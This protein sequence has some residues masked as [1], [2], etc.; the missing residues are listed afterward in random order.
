VRAKARNAGRGVALRAQIAAIAGVAAITVTA[1]CAVVKRPPTDVATLRAEGV[2][3]AAAYQEEMAAVVER[4]AQR[5]VRRGDG[6]L[7][8]LLLSGGGQSGAFGAGF[9][10]GWRA[11]AADPMPTFDL[12]TG[13]SAGALQAPFAFLGTEEA[14]ERNARLFRNENGK[15]EPKAD[16]L[17]WLRRTGGVVK[18]DGFNE[19]L[20][21]TYNASLASSLAPGFADGRQ[22]LVGTTDADLGIGRMWDV[23][24]ELD[25]SDGV[26][27]LQR[28]LLASTAVP[29][30]FPPVLLDGH[31]HFDGSVMGNFL[32]VLDLEQYRRLAARLR[33]LGAGAVTVRL[34][35]ILNV[36]PHADIK[37]MPPEEATSLALRATYLL[38]WA[39][40]PEILRGLAERAAAANAELDGL[41]VELRYTGVPDELSSDPKA[42]KLFDA[43]WTK[44][45][46]QLGYER[47]LGD[48]PWDPIPSAFAR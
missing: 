15:M 39:Q 8:I 26:E 46:E 47:A 33:E 27:R 22:I 12:V 3:A 4:L 10:R 5:A 37:V 19:T 28:V 32:T 25:R 40:Q 30:Y 23:R 48:S 44:R 41:E 16:F 14:T 38:Y 42:D 35:A 34:W 21:E 45:I 18:T 20:K 29:G 1:G 9:L 7:D 31:L 11:R 43:E 2:A 13:I 17:F 36:F 6:K 24:E